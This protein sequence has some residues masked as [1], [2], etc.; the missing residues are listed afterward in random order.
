MTI[1]HSDIHRMRRASELWQTVPMATRLRLVRRF[2]GL[3]R[4]KWRTLPE[5]FPNR[6]AVETITAEFLPFLAACKFLERNAANILR[7][8]RAGFWGRPTWLPGVTSIIKRQPYG[9][10]LILAPGNYPLMLPGIQILQSIVAGNAVALKPAPGGEPAAKMLSDLISSAGFPTGLCEILPTDSG[11]DAVAAGFDL[12]ILTGSART[13]RAVLEQASKTLTPT[14][15]ELSG[16]D[17]VFVLPDANLAHV[18]RKLVYGAR[19]NNGATCIAPHRVF[20]G[21]QDKTELV[22][23]LRNLLKKKKLLFV[24][25]DEKKRLQA[26]SA[27]IKASG[28]STET[29]GSVTLLTQIEGLHHLLDT[30]IFVPWLAIIG[31]ADVEEALNLDRQVSYALG[32]SIFGSEISAKL[33]AQ[34]VSAGSICINDLIVPTADPRLPFGGARSSGYGTTRGAEGLLSLTRPVVTSVRRD[35]F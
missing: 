16:V 5:L 31:V 15:M 22:D 20:I 23:R 28:G 14:I 10:V 33:I 11:S 24:D 18:A 6:P 35:I 7:A 34:K 2:R 3:L 17:P 21:H 30:D 4:Q 32:A 26:F 25:Q 19:L 8:R 9:T 13:G 29:I 1:S 27:T 12:I